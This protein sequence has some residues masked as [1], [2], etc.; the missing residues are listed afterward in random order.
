[1]VPKPRPDDNGCAAFSLVELLA[2]IAIILFL[3]AV[4]LPV[5][6]ERPHFTT[7]IPS[8]ISN[9]RQLTYAWRM[10]ADDN[11]GKLLNN[12]PFAGTLATPANNWVGGV[13]D[14]SANPQ[15]TN[16][17]FIRT[18]QL[19]MY[20]KNVAV[21]HCPNDKSVSAV[22]PRLRSYSMN[23]FVGDS[24]NGPVASGWKQFLKMSDFSNPAGTFVFVDEHPNSINDGCFVNDPANTNAWTDLPASHHYGGGGG[25]SFADGHAEIHRWVNRSTKQP[26]VPNRPK[27]YVTVPP[28]ERDDITWVLQRTIQK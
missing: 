12:H 22:G 17:D 15:N 8:C 13:M 16:V 20:I 18:G 3:A 9:S 1:M 28:A 23:G 4:F 2:M 21:Y 26:V 11:N 6:Q 7:G 19:W 25:F 5:F 24:G 10:Y 14:W 27:P